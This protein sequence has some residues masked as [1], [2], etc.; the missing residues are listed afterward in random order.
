LVA[1]GQTGNHRIKGIICQLPLKQVIVIHAINQ[2]MI[3][4]N[5]A[6]PSPVIHR[7]INQILIRKSN[8]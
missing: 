2:A 8:Y 6:W 1:E 3:L 7:I 4:V 5:I